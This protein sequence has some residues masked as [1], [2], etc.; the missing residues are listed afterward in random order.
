MPLG[1]FAAP[2]PLCTLSSSPGKVQVL[3]LSASRPGDWP[4][5]LMMMMLGGTCVLAD[6]VTSRPLGVHKP[7]TEK[8]GKETPQR[9]GSKGTRGIS[10]AATAV[11]LVRGSEVMD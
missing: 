3:T 4:A 1:Q 2:C 11:T 9:K 10:P 5:K 6:I 7:E 8:Q